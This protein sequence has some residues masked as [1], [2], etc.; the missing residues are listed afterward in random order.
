MS[1][2]CVRS[3]WLAWDKR[4]YQADGHN[5]GPTVNEL[6][7]EAVVGEDDA[8]RLGLADFSRL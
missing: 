6:D 2:H 4:G 7:D 5:D 1:R 3:T 8:L